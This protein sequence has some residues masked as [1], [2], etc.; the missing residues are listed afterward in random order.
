MKQ[1]KAKEAEEKTKD[2]KNQQ[3]ESEEEEEEE[4]EEEDEFFDEELGEKDGVSGFRERKINLDKN[5]SKL[6]NVIEKPLQANV[7]E[8]PVQ[9]E[10][11]D[12]ILERQDN[13]QSE[14]LKEITQLKKDEQAALIIE[15]NEEEEDEEEE[16]EEEEE[17]SKIDNQFE[18][19]LKNNEIDLPYLDEDDIENKNADA[20]ITSLF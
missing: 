19:A 18:N 1:A 4:E 3:E 5:E 16:E 11:F 15:S 8:K 7:I 2:V 6:A 13:K 17:Y 9:E 20:C 14:N 12:T 10:V